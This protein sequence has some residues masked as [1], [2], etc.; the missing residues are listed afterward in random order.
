MDGAPFVCGVTTRTNT[1]CP[2]AATWKQIKGGGMTCGRHRSPIFEIPDPCTRC[3]DRCM[4]SAT[5][6]ARCDQLDTI[7]MATVVRDV[8]SVPGIV[9]RI[10]SKMPKR[11][12]GKKG[13]FLLLNDE[14][15]RHELMPNVYSLWKHTLRVKMSRI[16][17]SYVKPIEYVRGFPRAQLDLE[18]ALLDYLVEAKECLFLVKTKSRTAFWR[19]VD[20]KLQAIQ[21]MRP[22]DR[23]L[24]THLKRVSNYRKELQ[25]FIDWGK[26]NKNT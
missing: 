5:K 2:C 18:F 26:E 20:D 25:S 19:I 3:G 12:V 17:N 4:Q 8:L 23:D 21:D 6:R 16:I 9:S 14:R 7:H 24:D 10:A 13:L 22:T 1:L 11:D 15:H